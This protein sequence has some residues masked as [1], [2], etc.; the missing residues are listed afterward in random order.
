MIDFKKNILLPSFQNGLETV[1]RYNSKAN[2]TKYKEMRNMSKGYAA[3]SWTS[4]STSL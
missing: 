2:G 1:E 4:L 3:V